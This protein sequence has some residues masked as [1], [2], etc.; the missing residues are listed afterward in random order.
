MSSRKA[1]TASCNRARYFRHIL[2]EINGAELLNALSN[3]VTQ[4]GCLGGE[5][6]VHPHFLIDRE[7]SAK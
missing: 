6:C 1:S 2:A 3:F 4:L 5:V 7:H